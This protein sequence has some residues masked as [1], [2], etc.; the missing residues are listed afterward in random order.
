MMPLPDFRN[1]GVMLRALLLPLAL[2][3]G[4]GLLAWSR[5]DPLW[6]WLQTALALVPGSLLS[7]ALLALAGPRLTRRRRGAWWALALVGACFAGCGWCL[8]D[9]TPPA[10]AAPLLAMLAAA[11][12]LHY[13]S[14]RQ[15]ALSPALADARLAALQARI[16]PHFLFNSLNAAIALIR[17]RPAQAEGVLENLAELF[18]AQ[19]ADPARASTLAREVELAR[20]YLAIESVRLGPRLQVRWRLEAPLDAALPPLILQPLVENAVYHGAERLAGEVAI[21]VSARLAGS[22]L[23]L[24]LDNPVP[25]AE[26]GG[27]VGSGMALSNLRERLELFFDAEAS[28]TGERHGER[29]R[30]RV[31]L[32]YRRAAD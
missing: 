21:D 15:R 23:E 22:Q 26:D 25:A 28:L 11:A 32:P 7:L 6:S 18:R 9:A 1:L 17:Q 10:P 27:R 19:M 31:R 14:L 29:Y 5:P 24:T 20:M 12:G 13:L 4:D 8:R 16:R 30:T 2:L 3:L